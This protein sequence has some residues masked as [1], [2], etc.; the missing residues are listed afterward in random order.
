VEPLPWDIVMGLGLI[1]ALVGACQTRTYTRRGTRYGTAPSSACTCVCMAYGVRPAGDAD[2][3]WQRYADGLLPA[4]EA[5]TLPLTWSCE[6]L[7]QLQHAAI[8]EAAAAQQ[9]RGRGCADAESSLGSPR[10]SIYSL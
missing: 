10:T 8:A 2:G 9:V 5:L 6:R 4:P 7:A 3:F 1:D